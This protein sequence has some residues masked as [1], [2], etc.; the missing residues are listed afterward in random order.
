MTSLY[1]SAM[2]EICKDFGGYPHFNKNTKVLYNYEELITKFNN[3]KYSDNDVDFLK[4]AFLVECDI[5]QPLT[6]DFMFQNY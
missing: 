3:Y 5:Y 6:K 1:P 2:K 4:E